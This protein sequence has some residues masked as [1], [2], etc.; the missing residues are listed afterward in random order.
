MGCP[1]MVIQFSCFGQISKFWFWFR[2]PAANQTRQFPLILKWF[3]RS[4]P[5]HLHF[6]LQS[7]RGRAISPD[8]VCDCFNFRI[9]AKNPILPKIGTHK[10]YRERK[11][12]SGSGARNE[13][14]WWKTG[15]DH[16]SVISRVENAYFH[17]II[18]PIPE[19]QSNLCKWI[20]SDLDYF[21]S[22]SESWINLNCQY[23]RCHFFRFQTT[24]L[25]QFLNFARLRQKKNYDL[26]CA[27]LFYLLLPL[28]NHTTDRTSTCQKRH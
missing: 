24:L 19:L 28:N 23:L 4:Q 21:Y 20:F 9:R 14:L 27:R 13:G 2:L 26:R 3:W 5:I 11:R 6:P 8:M 25:R 16:G 15:T 18:E 7:C 12:E 10:T 1:F 17:P 22:L